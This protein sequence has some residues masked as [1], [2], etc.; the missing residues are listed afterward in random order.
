MYTH[1]LALL[2]DGG[3]EL[4]I[5]VISNATSWVESMMF[6]AWGFDE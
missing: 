6:D 4:G 3:I 5:M 2:T 1:I